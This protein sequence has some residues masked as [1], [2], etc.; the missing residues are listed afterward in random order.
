MSDWG[1]KVP[2]C[3]YCEC[4]DRAMMKCHPESE[5]CKKE[6][7]LEEADF[8]KECRCDFFRKKKSE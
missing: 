4:A 3:A 1:K 7:D 5:D 6:Y 8:H 2:G